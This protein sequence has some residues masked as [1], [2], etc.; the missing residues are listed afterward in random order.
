M[1]GNTVCHVIF[2]IKYS[3]IHVC[4]Q[5]RFLYLSFQLS[6]IIL[7]DNDQRKFAEAV[8]KKKAMEAVNE[9]AADNIAKSKEN[10]RQAYAK[11]VLKKY[12]NIM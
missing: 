9:K 6:T 10:Q 4:S 11:R 3:C 12:K 5:V 8:E 7:S 2:G 1:S